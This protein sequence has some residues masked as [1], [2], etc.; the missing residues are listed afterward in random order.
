MKLEVEVISKEIIKPSS[1]TPDHVRHYQLSFLDQVSPM[2]YNPIVLFYSSDGTTQ[3]NRTTVSKKLK[4]SLS[5]V[6]THFYPLAGRVNGNSFID[7]NDEG[8]PY[9]EAKVKC[10]LVDVIHKPVPGELNQLIPFLLDDITNITF[11]VQLN[12]FDCG[13][14]AIGA[15]LSHQIADGLSFF[16]FLNCWAA[17]TRGQAVLPNPQFVSPKLFPPKNISGFDPRSGIMKDN[18]VCKMFVFD[19]SVIE[20]LRARYANAPSLE[21]EKRPTRVEALSTFIWSRYVAVTRD[22]QQSGPQ[23]TYAVIHAVNLR[24]KMEPPLPPDSFGNYYRI[25]MTIPSFNTGEECFGLVK[26]VRDQ[27]KKIDKDYVRKLQE[28]NE[29]L[30]FLKDSS[31]RVLVKGEFVS[32][33]I[34]S[35]CRFPLYDADFGLGKPTWVGSPAL[36]FKNLVV[37][38]DTKN[39]GGIEAYVSLKVEDMTKFEADE[40]LLACVNKAP[41]C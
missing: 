23:R 19:S 20:N 33:N 4:K 29:H 6:L 36:T 26:Q 32:F 3:F 15:C 17:I 13:G 10:K 37:F 14:I 35:L 18:I 24:P 9:L 40:E 30:D 31:Y 8:I 11:G 39:G 2:V 1:P 5:D 12:V 22:Q 28:G 16:T 7:C 25:T 38:I 27:I 41:S 34:T 21:N